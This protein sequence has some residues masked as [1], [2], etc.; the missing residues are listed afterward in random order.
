LRRNREPRD[1][2]YHLKF[3][4]PERYTLAWTGP[5]YVSDQHAEIKAGTL[6]RVDRFDLDASGLQDFNIEFVTGY[7]PALAKSND[8]ACLRRYL[9]MENA[10]S[11]LVIR[12]LI[13]GTDDPG[14][15]RLEA[16]N[17]VREH[18]SGLYRGVITHS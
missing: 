1:A 5:E 17:G 13:D 16:G 4:N 15:L 6:M 18:R 14:A 11:H 9:S 12:E 7:L 10:P 8:V 3:R 2:A